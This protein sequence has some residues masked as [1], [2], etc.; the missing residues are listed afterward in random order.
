MFPTISSRRL[1][2]AALT[3]CVL[4][5]AVTTTVS[6]DT[7]TDKVTPYLDE[8]T[9][10]VAHID[11]DNFEP[12][13]WLT[14]I[15][16][17]VIKAN[18]AAGNDASY[19]VQAQFAGS[20]EAMDMMHSAVLAAGVHEFYLIGSFNMLGSGS[21]VALVAPLDEQVN[22]DAAAEV[23]G[24]V[25]PATVVA[26]NVLLA[27]EAAALT[28][29]QATTAT[30]R[31]G[32]STAFAATDANDPLRAAVVPAPFV[33]RVVRE[34]FPEVPAEF[35][36][37]SPA[38]LTAGLQWI[39]LSGGLPAMTDIALKIETKHGDAASDLSAMVGRLLHGLVTGP[40]AENVRDTDALVRSLMPVT[41][42]SALIWDL[43]EA[44]V[45]A[46]LDQL[47][48]TLQSSRDGAM[49]VQLMNQTRV[50]LVGVYTYVAEHDD[51]FP[52]SIEAMLA[53]GAYFERDLLINPRRPD[54]SPGL[55]YRKPP[56]PAD[57][58][59]FDYQFIMLHETYD[60]WPE[61]GIVAG[62]A[63]AHVEVIVDEADFR[64]R[65]GE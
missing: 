12:G 14:A 63:D 8:S 10:L 3:V 27:G 56:W 51:T 25:F 41:A 23:F 34:M 35:G 50:I 17:L 11:V 5:A 47:V 29:L 28:A 59:D 15:E 31:P 19:D 54:A 42:G 16:P 37:G 32:F 38:P 39:A 65:L 13:A 62:F 40:R 46:I 2:G 57:S 44:G 30:P 48:P 53:V 45:Q 64:K 55:V 24:Q 36:G 33:R 6:A 61:G 21:P 22:Q 60:V 18:T 1:V 58:K 9:W 43:D 49:K 7:I 20:R 26:G 52:E 4:S